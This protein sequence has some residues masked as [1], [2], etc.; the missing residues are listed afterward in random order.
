MQ[1]ARRAEH[2]DLVATVRFRTE[3]EG[4]RKT[5]PE[6]SLNAILTVGERNFDVRLTCANSGVAP[7]REAVVRIDF[8][9]P[10]IAREFVS[11]GQTFTL[12][13][14]RVIADGRVEHIDFRQS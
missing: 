1:L 11:P 13:D 8:L 14:W 2:A 10:R 9:E 12:R 4:G 7:G 3:A 5:I 6:D